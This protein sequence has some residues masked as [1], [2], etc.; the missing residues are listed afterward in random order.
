MFLHS[1][2]E[3]ILSLACGPSGVFVAR[4]VVLTPTA[5]LVLVSRR[6]YNPHRMQPV[7][8]TTAASR[9]CSN[10][11]RGLSRGWVDVDT[12]SRQHGEGRRLGA[13]GSPKMGSKR[14][15]DW[16]CPS[17]KSN[18]FASKR[19]CFLCQ[20]PKPTDGEVV[21]VG[22]EAAPPLSKPV[23]QMKMAE[24]RR[25]LEARGLKPSGLRPALVARLQGAVL[26]SGEALHNPKPV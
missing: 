16:T 23:E 26:A 9:R 5:L 20:T 4:P 17:C 11:H 18:V 21:L 3:L 24:L 19:E 8:L 12:P 10:P 14:A 13:T 7:V 25:A 6:V 2:Q 15:G 22:G 1:V